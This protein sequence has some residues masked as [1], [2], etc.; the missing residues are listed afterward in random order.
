MITDTFFEKYFKNIKVVEL[1]SVLA[2]PQVGSFLAELG[3]KVVKV[4][5]KLQNGDP[6]R[7]WKLQSENSQAPITSYYASA[8]YNKESILL[9]LTDSI[10]YAECIRHVKN[11]D[12]VISNFTNKVAQK[13]KV[14][15]KSVRELNENIIFCQLYGYTH[16]DQRPGYDLIMQA[17]AGY[18]YMNGEANSIPVKMPVAL[19]DLMAAHQMKESILLSLLKKE[20][21]NEGSYVEVSLYKS[22]IASLANQA[23]NFLMEGHVP[24]RMGS[25]HPNIAPYGEQFTSADGIQFIIAIGSDAQFNKLG[26][27]LNESI[28]LVSKFE[29]NM[30]RVK[31]RKELQST[32]QSEF[33]LA[34]FNKI[35]KLLKNI[36]VAFCQIKTMNEVFAEPIA[37]SMILES[38]IE[39][40]TAKCVS[41]LSFDIK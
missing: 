40:Y 18:M 17:E 29:S 14:D 10:D 34:N 37:K 26:K 35:S 25:L 24:Q 21:T 11:A 15:Y 5:N 27:T 28:L 20:K 36:G 4:E 1:A 41:Q 39:G 22:A 31:H 38:E 19:I 30:S 7:Q 13:L 32:L 12:I 16:D 23:S 9:N 8:N 3:A 6:T 2:G 33:H